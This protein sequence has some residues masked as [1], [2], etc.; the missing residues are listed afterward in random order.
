MRSPVDVRV[1]LGEPAGAEDDVKRSGVEV[2]NEEVLGVDVGVQLELLS[3]DDLKRLSVAV[4]KLENS[5]SSTE[6]VSW[7]VV[8]SK[9]AQKNEV[10][11]GTTVDEKA[12]GLALEEAVYNQE[13]VAQIS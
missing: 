4:G 1:D 11:G 7:Q 6:G 10:A 12:S 9:E 3:G 8:L 2:G 13:W 5:R